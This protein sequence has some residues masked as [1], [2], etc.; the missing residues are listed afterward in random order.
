VNYRVSKNY[1]EIMN[2][3]LSKYD[4]KLNNQ[5]LENLFHKLNHFENIKTDYIDNFKDMFIKMENSYYSKSSNMLEYF[6]KNNLKKINTKTG[7]IKDYTYKNDCFKYLKDFIKRKKSFL[8]EEKNKGEF[9]NNQD[10]LYSYKKISKVKYLEHINQHKEKV[11]ITF[12]LPNIIFHKYDK[13]GNFT[14]TYK[15][16]DKF[17]ENILKGLKYLN[18][19]IHRYFYTTLKYKIDRHCKK[20]KIKNKDKKRIDYI[21]MLEPHKNLSGHL[22]SLFYIDNDFKDIIYNVYNMTIEHYK[23]KQTKFETLNSSKGSTYVSKYLLKTTKKGNEFYNHYKRYF[24]NVKLFSSSNFKYTTQEKI[25]L[26]YKYLYE[27][28]PLLLER[29]KKGNKPLYYVL[30][31]LIKRKIFTFEEKKKTSL[32]INFS[33]IKKEYKQIIKKFNIDKFCEKKKT[34]KSNIVKD[35]DIEID[36]T[37]DNLED[38][39]FTE[40]YIKK[41]YSKITKDNYINRFKTNVI[42]NLKEYINISNKKVV[43]KMYFKNDLVLNK[44]DW[45]FI[46]T[47]YKNL[48]KK[49]FLEI[50]E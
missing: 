32:T 18:E 41:E 8:F 6:V 21:K 37:I 19:E 36:L 35:N 15:T 11:F 49:P 44:E 50:V 47:D 10:R 38:L 14:K 39:Y 45:E 30:E 7:E 23:L 3:S 25:E 22:H 24:S 42:E 46:K 29:Y 40:E 20:H 33:K 1:I 13:N 27:N 2:K 12:T 9:L 31:I 43:S 4:K 26:V 48:M 34:K 28:K 5:Q 16:Q 17:E